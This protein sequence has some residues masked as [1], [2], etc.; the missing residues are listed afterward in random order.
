[1]ERKPSSIE[2]KKVLEILEIPEVQEDR[3]RQDEREIYLPM[4]GRHTRKNLM[5]K[6]KNLVPRPR[7][8]GK[9]SFEREKSIHQENHTVK[10]KISDRK[11][12]P[13]KTYNERIKFRSTYNSYLGMM[14][15]R[16]TYRLRKYMLELLPAPR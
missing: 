10:E 12:N 9:K 15:H 4:A 6:E 13:P 16:S 7:M 8:W 3:I 5:A 2:P 11:E 1:M 14:K